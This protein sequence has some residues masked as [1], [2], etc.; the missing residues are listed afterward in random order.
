MLRRGSNPTPCTIG[1]KLNK[2]EKEVSKI[3]K[4]D[5]GKKLCSSCHYRGEVWPH[6]MC[7]DYMLM[8][9]KRRGCHAGN[10]CTKYKKSN[11]SPERFRLMKIQ[12][13]QKIAES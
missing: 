10:G 11:M 5:S 1:K 9:G 4:K 3:T 7:C 12:M 8:T 6:D 2:L 13:M